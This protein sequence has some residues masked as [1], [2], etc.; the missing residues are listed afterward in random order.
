MKPQQIKILVVDPEAASA[1][2]TTEVLS[3]QGYQVDVARSSDDALSKTAA[4][5]Y[6]LIITE[7]NLNGPMGGLDMV[8]QFRD[9]HRHTCAI[10]LTSDPSLASAVQAI[11]L[12]VCD[13]L[14]KPVQDDSLLESVNRSLSR[15][16]IYLTSEATI[17]KSIGARL[18]QLRREMGLTTQ[19]LANRVGVTQSQISQ[20]ET[21]RSAASVVTLYK[22]AQAFEM[23]LGEMLQ[24]V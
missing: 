20:V 16:G 7:M 9:T 22:I 4:T 10:V 8:R 11:Q 12:G 19:Q 21:G 24:G 5:I 2:K 1:A 6:H 13:Y 18:R 23:S 17:N 3:T 15:R 14:S